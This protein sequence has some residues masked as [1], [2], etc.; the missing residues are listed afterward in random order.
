[1]SRPH[2][3][4]AAVF[5]A[6]SASAFATEKTLPQVEIE[7]NA[8][9]PLP[10]AS[11]VRGL[12]AKRAATSD[13]AALLRDVPGVQLNGAGGVS[14]LPAVHGLADDRLR[15]R[16]DGMDLVATCPNHMNPPL[17]YLDPAQVASLQVYAG[18]A[19]VSLGGDSIGGSIVATTPA[20]AF[21]ATGETR[22]GG[23]VASFYR[24]N[25]AALGG[26][27]DLHW[28][29][30]GFHVGYRGGSSRADNYRAG[31]DFKTVASTGRPAHEL[32]LDEVGST[33]YETANHALTLALKRDAHLLEAKLGYQDMP[34]QL[35]PNQRMDLLDNTQKRGSVRY[36]GEFGWGALDASA[37]HERVDHFMDFGPDKR[38]WYGSNSGPGNPCDPIRYMGDPAGTC[39]G[40]MPMYSAGRTSGA[41]IAADLGFAAA[42]LL[43]VGA[44]MQRYELDDWWT[45]SGGGMGPGVFWNIADGERDR[46]AL[47][48]EWEQHLS[49]AWLTLLGARFEQVHTDAGDVRG[50]STMANAPGGQ[51]AEANAF[52]A[53]ERERSDHNWD[54][55]ALARYTPGPR[56]DLEF[57]LARKTRTPNLYERYTWSSW[58]MA[59]TMNNFV[60]DGNGYI[61]SIDLKPEVAHTL[62]ATLDWHAADRAW[63]L[64]A[65]PHYTSVQDYIDALPRTGWVANRFNVLQLSNQ[66][67]RLYG[68]DLS[69]EARLGE[70]GLGAFAFE[71]IVNHLR[72][73]NRDRDDDLY[74]L[75]PLNARLRLKHSLAGW[76]S[77]LEWELVD[78]KEHVS[79][80]RNE[81]PT[82]GY[83]LLHL[84]TSREFGR[85]RLDAGVENLFD[86]GYRLPTGG[87][88]LGQGTTMSMNGLPWGIAVPGMGRSV[89]LG[90][91]LGF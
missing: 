38:F 84:R 88:Y 89:H 53:R 70:G 60:G 69:G 14:S 64:R 61:G 28:A 11:P 16:V 34:E 82:D 73:V 20:P 32:S 56:F 23:E 12:K 79:A 77:V 62:S 81:V 1:M 57:G 72:G 75:M 87:A 55:T 37:Y 24:S 47:F 90:L 52:N 67:A 17:S 48:A 33:A 4:A 83:G 13:T 65:T 2:A 45:P 58:P 8:P 50:Y 25:H 29:N 21:A 59:A 85:L 10:N 31:R 36:R 80:V 19:P 78:A 49:D 7:E 51:Y 5:A 74:N 71:G 41:R 63:Q 76:N 42:D 66:S 15:I 91:S 30:D 26:S 6:L 44:E 9:A 54:L 3:L 46:N 35:F 40:G 18:I 22:A 86:R 68:I 27:V 43:R 39:A